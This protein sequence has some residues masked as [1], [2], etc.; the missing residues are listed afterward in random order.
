MIE[1]TGRSYIAGNWEAPEGE[2]FQSFNPYNKER[3]YKFASCGVTEIEQ[4]APGSGKCFP[5]VSQTGW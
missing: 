3:M 1:I 4:A 2:T 5:A